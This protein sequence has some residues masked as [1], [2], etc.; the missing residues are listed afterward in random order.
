MSGLLS[1]ERTNRPLRSEN[2]IEAERTEWQSM[3][4]NVVSCKPEFAYTGDGTIDVC[5]EF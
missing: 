2:H 4:W 5:L 3:F 1:E